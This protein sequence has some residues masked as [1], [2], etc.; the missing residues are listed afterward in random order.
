MTETLAHGYSSE[1]PHREV[2][3][4]YQHD[5]YLRP[6]A[7]DEGSLSIGRV[8]CFI[9]AKANQAFS[10]ERDVSTHVKPPRKPQSL[11]TFPHAEIRDRVH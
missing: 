4:E 5:N 7:L 3:N 8:D 2:S 6:C 11:A 1:S 10:D 9:Q